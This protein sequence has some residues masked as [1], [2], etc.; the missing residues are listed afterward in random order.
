[1]MN[2]NCRELN[3]DELTMVIG[4]IRVKRENDPIDLNIPTELEVGDSNDRKVGIR[5]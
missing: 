2:I 3:I 5:V 4:G 1:M